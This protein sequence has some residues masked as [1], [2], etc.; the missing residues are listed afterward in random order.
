MKIGQII[1]LI[2]LILVFLDF[3]CPECATY[4]AMSLQTGLV[5]NEANYFFPSPSPFSLTYL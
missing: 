3:E 1:F 5:Q 4:G 2:L